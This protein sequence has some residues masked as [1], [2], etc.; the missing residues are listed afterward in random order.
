MKTGN[1]S[2]SVRFHNDLIKPDSTSLAAGEFLFQQQRRITFKRPPELGIFPVD[3]EQQVTIFFTL[4]SSNCTGR[5]G[6][7]GVHALVEIEDD[8]PGSPEDVLP[9]LFDSFFTTKAP[10][11]GTGLVLDI[12][13]GIVVH[14]HGVRID[15]DTEPGRTTMQVRLPLEGP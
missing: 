10:G 3:P 8:G 13:Y 4:D 11:S 1:R 14:R 9:R 7:D 5:I 6:V 2:P 15:I 12:F